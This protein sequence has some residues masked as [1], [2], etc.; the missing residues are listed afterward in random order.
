MKLKLTVWSL[1]I[2]ILVSGVFLV[3]R[4]FGADDYRTLSHQYNLIFEEFLR[5]KIAKIPKNSPVRLDLKDGRI[6]FGRF[7]GFH[8]YDD[9]IWIRPVDARWGFLSDDA[10]DVR[11]L[12]DINVVVFENI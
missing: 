12:L 10:Y 5:I 11:E 4:T 6:L 7:K 1:L 8:K 3:S 2:I 9:S